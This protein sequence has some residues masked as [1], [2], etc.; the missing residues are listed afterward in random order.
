M[1]TM[2]YKIL[3]NESGVPVLIKMPIETESYDMTHFH[4]SVIKRYFQALKAAMKPENQIHFK[5]PIGIM[6]SLL[7][8]GI[9]EDVTP[10]IVGQT[11]DLPENIGVSFED[12]GGHGFPDK[13]VAILTPITE[14]PEPEDIT[15]KPVYTSET[16][17]VVAPVKSE[18]EDERKIL[19]KFLDWYDGD[20]K[21]LKD[22]DQLVNEYFEER[23]G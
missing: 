13:N 7:R 20:L 15:I 8:N 9:I 12:D 4:K 14:A 11:F 21:V 22:H 10:S 23:K 6:D 3:I 16:K 2:N 18:G 17:L 1:K 5:D 19:L